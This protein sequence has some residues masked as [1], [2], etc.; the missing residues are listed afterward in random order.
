MNTT[1]KTLLLALASTLLLS[2]CAGDYAFKSNLDGDAINEYFKPGDVT[3]FTDGQLPKGQY[4]I[5]GLVEGLSCQHTE[6]EVPATK[7]QAR[8][9]A[10]RKAA[11]LG[12]NGMIVQNCHL[13]EEPDNTCHTQA[14][15]V[16]KAIQL[17]V[18]P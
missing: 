9:Q 12:A 5:L 14:M 7:R 10:R 6:N 2:A 18:Q 8:T 4:K 13:I 1:R 16:G 11:D 17:P 15:C 3:L